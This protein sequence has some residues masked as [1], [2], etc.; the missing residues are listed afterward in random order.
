MSLN[1]LSTPPLNV[2]GTP[3]RPPPYF[4]SFDSI[5]NT[6]MCFARIS[7]IFVKHW[8]HATGSF[9]DIPY[10]R[11]HWI[12]FPSR[13]LGQ[14]SVCSL[15]VQKYMSQ[16]RSL[17]HLASQQLTWQHCD[18]MF[19]A[20]HKY[21]SFFICCKC[22]SLC[23]FYLGNITFTSHIPGFPANNCHFEKLMRALRLDSV[24]FQVL[25][26][27]RFTIIHFS[28]VTLEHGRYL[29]HS[30]FPWDKSINY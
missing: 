8:A 10:F 17:S 24:V 11:K 1:W 22:A 28:K 19:H 9:Q 6:I 16:W 13:T 2:A 5:S 25:V 4:G 18:A 20:L 26:L 23:S 12:E 3:K 7:T 15:N 30:S 14:G 29:S 21:L 27:L